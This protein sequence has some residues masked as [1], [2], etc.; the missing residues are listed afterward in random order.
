MSMGGLEIMHTLKYYAQQDNHSN[1][2][3]MLLSAVRTD[4]TL[5]RRNLPDKL[6]FFSRHLTAPVQYTENQLPYLLTV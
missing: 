2:E 1:G 6:L 5:K 3:R 4:K